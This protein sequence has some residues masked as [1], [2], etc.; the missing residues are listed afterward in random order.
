MDLTC[1]C[2][3]DHLVANGDDIGSELYAKRLDKHDDGHREHLSGVYT[4]IFR[5]FTGV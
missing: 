3:I 1:R 5:I 4:V 2:S